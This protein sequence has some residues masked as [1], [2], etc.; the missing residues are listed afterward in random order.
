LSDKYKVTIPIHEL[1]SAE[2]LNKHCFCQTLNFDRLHQQLEANPSLHQVM[3][4]ITQTHPHLFA[5]SAVF[6]SQ[7]ME[8]K[9]KDAISAI[10][11]VIAL[12][13]YQSFVLNT[14]P[15]IA[16]HQFGPRGVCMG[17]DFHLSDEGPKLIEINTNAGGLLLNLALARAQE[18]CCVEMDQTFIPNQKLEKMEQM[19]FEMFLAE[20]KSQRGHVS[21]GLVVIVDDDPERQY[22]AP[23][24]ELFRSLLKNHNVQAVIAD[25]KELS[26]H[27]NLLWH[28]GVKVDLVYNRLTDF[29]LDEA[30]H[31]NLKLAYE[32]GAV[33]LTPAPFTHLLYADK[34]NLI[35]LSQSDQLKEW[36]VSDQDLKILHSCIPKTRRV[37]MEDADELWSGRKHLFFKPCKGY[38]SKA[39]YRGDKITKKVWEQILQGEFVAQEL[40]PPSERLIQVDGQLNDLKF[41]VRAYTYVGNVQL[42]AARMYAGQTTN[43]RTEGGGFAPIVTVAMQ[44]GN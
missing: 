41:D 14:A 5:S 35:T 40:I 33:V 27:D 30:H 22:L 13:Q 42:M 11:R 44:L 29:Y 28:E 18:S 26:W 8:Q 16:R 1:S 24:F 23:E 10:E 19:L 34:R 6:L 12:P 17:Y 32:Q 7:E 38:A 9:I 25:P 36:G 20:W 2:E 3:G 4:D 43:F 39:A 37:R 21:L 15:E 31:Q